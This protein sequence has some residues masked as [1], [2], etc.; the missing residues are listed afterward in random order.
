M[1]YGPYGMCEFITFDQTYL[2]YIEYSQIRYSID[3]CIRREVPFPIRYNHHKVFLLKLP[4][5][6]EFYQHNH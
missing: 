5:L 2:F 1:V 3:N 6:Q 4:N